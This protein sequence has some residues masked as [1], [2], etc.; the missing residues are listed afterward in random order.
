MRHREAAIAKFIGSV[1]M[2]TACTAVWHAHGWRLWLLSIAVT[3]VIRLAGYI[4]GRGE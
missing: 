1:V 2:M 3:V 4:E